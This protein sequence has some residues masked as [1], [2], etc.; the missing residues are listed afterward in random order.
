MI[1]ETIQETRREMR[2]AVLRYN[3][4]EALILICDF[5]QCENGN[6]CPWLRD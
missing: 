2:I 4:C 6:F 1:H 5:V 3:V